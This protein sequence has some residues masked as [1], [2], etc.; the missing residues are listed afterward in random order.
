MAKP[1]EWT[2]EKLA[3]LKQAPSMP[4]PDDERRYHLCLTALREGASAL[5]DLATVLRQGIRD[6]NGAKRGSI[7]AGFERAAALTRGEVLNIAPD[8]KHDDAPDKPR[9]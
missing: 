9:K 7:A 1:T 3:A 2:P 4:L 8:P 5:S 6:D